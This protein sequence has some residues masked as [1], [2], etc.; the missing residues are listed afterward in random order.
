MTKYKELK[1]LNYRWG[2]VLEPSTLEDFVEKRYLVSIPKS[3]IMFEETPWNRLKEIKVYYLE[4]A[5]PY[6]IANG[7]E[8]KCTYW[9]GGDSTTAHAVLCFTKKV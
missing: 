1:L 2:Q 5:F 7:W 8:Y 9:K 3:E 4:D 6:I